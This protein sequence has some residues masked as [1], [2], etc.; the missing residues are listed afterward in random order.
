MKKLILSALTIC[1]LNTVAYA[2]CSENGCY[3]VTIDRLSVTD[4]GKILVGTSGDEGNLDC[5]AG[6]GVYLQ[7]TN[8]S[9]GQNAI[10]SM[11]LTA[12]TTNKPIN[13][14]IENDSAG[15]TVKYAFIK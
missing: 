3:N 8:D 9:V 7:V 12:K 15:C 1:T 6:A 14:R 11:L 2:D 13:I 5:T 4:L 10:Y